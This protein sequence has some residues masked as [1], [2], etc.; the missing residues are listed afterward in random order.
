[1]WKNGGSDPHAVWHHR[2]DGSRDEARGLGILSKENLERA[3]VTNGDFTAYVCD[4]A[5]TRLS[6]QI[7]LGRLVIFR[8]SKVQVIVCATSF[9]LAQWPTA[10]FSSIVLA[11]ALACNQAPTVN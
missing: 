2:S 5:A 11:V 1:M 6:S 7:T 3:I 4:S 10:N 8:E 9:T